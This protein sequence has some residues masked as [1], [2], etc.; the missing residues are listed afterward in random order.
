MPKFEKYVRHGDSV[1]HLRCYCNQLRV[2]GGR[3]E[4]LM[5]FFGESLFGLASEW[6]VDQD[7]GNWKKWDDLDNEFVQHFQYNVD[8]V[9]DKKSLVNMK[10]KS[11]EGFREYAIRWREQATRVKPLMKENKLVEAFIQ[12]QNET[13]FQHLL[14]A[15]GNS[16]I[17]VLKMGEMIDDG[18]KTKQI[19]SFA[20]LK[21][22]TQEIQGGF[23]T[24]GGK[25]KKEDVATIAAGSHSYPKRPPRPDYQP[26]AQVYDQAPY[27]PPHHYYPP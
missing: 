6:F 22:T 25:K 9:P 3:K 2:A 10:K 7:I 24:F 18:I 26:Q 20:A 1:V 16:F 19:I 23:G 21:A 14:S 12:A 17:E 13:Y 8:L 5:D 11:T 15:M 27:I 4:L